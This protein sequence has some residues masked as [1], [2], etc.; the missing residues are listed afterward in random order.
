MNNN[1]YIAY[2]ICL[3]ENVELTY[4]KLSLVDLRHY[5]FNYWRAKCYQIYCDDS[6]VKCFELY[7]KPEKAV[8]KFLELK[9][10][11]KNPMVRNIIKRYDRPDKTV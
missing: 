7:D 9:E 2:L 1:E 11:I 4:G 8:A 6:N 10:K 5:N 3:N